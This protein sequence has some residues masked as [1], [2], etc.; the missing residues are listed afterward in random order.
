MWDSET[1]E[2]THMDNVK[3]LIDT[4]NDLGSQRIPFLFI[5]DFDLQ[6][7]LIYTLDALSQ[8]TDIL[9]KVGIQTNAKK[10]Q[11]PFIQNIFFHK[12]PLSYSTYL[13]AFTYVKNAIIQGDSFLVNLTLPTPVE[14]NLSLS[15]IFYLSE[16]KYKLYVKDQFVLFSP[17]TFIEIIDGRIYSYPMKGTIDASIENAAECI[18]SDQKEMAEHVT[19]VDLIR[20]DLS[21]EARNVK[22]DT[23]RY[24]DEIDTLGG[25]LLQ[26]SSQISGVLP[27]GYHRRLGE[28]VISMLPAGSITGAPKPKTVEIIQQAEGYDRGYYTGVFGIFD[29][30][31]LKSAV[32]IRFIEKNG[33]ELFYKSGGGITAMSEPEKEYQEL[34]QKVYVPFVRKYQNISTENLQPSLPRR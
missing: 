9:Y 14:T 27:E 19:I 1:M 15:D 18:L 12:Y 30:W 20:N 11:E 31:D 13:K 8:D 25:K 21:M 2:N 33:N 28:I 16:A 5:L 32:M 29:G 24:I 23:F 7:P 34:I 17:E 26:V 10:H 4:F 22:V 3:Q 6:R